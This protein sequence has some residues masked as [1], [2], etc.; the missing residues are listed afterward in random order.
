MDRT[1]PATEAAKCLRSCLMKKYNVVSTN[2]MI[3]C[4][5]INS[6]SEF[7]Q[8]D[9]NGKFVP[10]VALDEARRLTNGSMEKIKIA[11]ALIR[12][13]AD[14]QVSVNDCEAAAEYDFCFRQEVQ[15]LGLPLY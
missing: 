1:P 6:H 14:I 15:R 12:A 2:N 10:S 8:M 13:C 7:L 11:I 5:R 3:F 4:I 9:S